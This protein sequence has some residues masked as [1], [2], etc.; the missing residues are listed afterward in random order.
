MSTQ[1]QINQVNAA[2]VSFQEQLM[3]LLTDLASYRYTTFTPSVQTPPTLDK[4]DPITVGALTP[5]GNGTSIDGTNPNNNPYT[6]LAANILNSLQ[7][8]KPSMDTSA[9][10]AFTAQVGALNPT[11]FTWLYTQIKDIVSTGGQNIAPAIQDSI[12]N[13]GYE[14]DLRA[15]ND[16]LQLSGAMV[17]GKG[18]R[19]PNS[20]IT[21]RQAVVSQEYQNSRNDTSRKIIETMGNLAQSNLQA[22]I[23]AGVQID[24]AI[25]S[26]FTEQT[27]ALTKIQELIL[28]EYKTDALENFQIFEAYIR[29]QMADMEVQKADREEMRAWIGEMRDQIRLASQVIISEFEVGNRLQVL[30]VEVQK[31]IADLVIKGNEQSV[32]VFRA[33]VEQMT[34]LQ[35]LMMTE[36]QENNK[37]Q[38]T[39]LESTARSFA[40]LIKSMAVQ[41]VSIQTSTG[42]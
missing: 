35:E 37:L 1:D 39:Q 17:G 21:A 15:F 40:E 6:P 34:K 13:T 31:F 4:V 16:A 27:N 8:T 11:L 12:S 32:A 36:I 3:G 29:L 22:A 41:G 10:A 18:A 30:Q 25:A 23:G 24:H 42:S 7:Y 26:I 19:L 20:A 14:R 5:L 2:V 28:E 38:Q 33:N 9:G